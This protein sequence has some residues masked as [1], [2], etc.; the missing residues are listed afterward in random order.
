MAGPSMRTA[1]LP[2]GHRI[3]RTQWRSTSRNS[4]ASI[5]CSIECSIHCSMERLIVASTECSMDA[6]I[7][8]LFHGSI[9][10]STHT[11][12]MERSIDAPME[13]SIDAPFNR[14]GGHS[15]PFTGWRKAGILCVCIRRRPISSIPSTLSMTGSATL[16]LS[17]WHH[18]PA[19]YV[20]LCVVMPG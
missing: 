19:Q 10:C 6:S 15:K 14:L 16:K 8:C 11:C 13:C 3:A 5:E 12:S 7:K 18:S 2:S 9:E 20:S 4:G 17:C 1:C